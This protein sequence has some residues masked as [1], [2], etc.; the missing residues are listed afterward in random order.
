MTRPV[1][2]CRG[3]MA[4]CWVS[5]HTRSRAVACSKQPILAATPTMC[6]PTRF[7]GA[8]PRWSSRD[9]LLM[10]PRCCV[11]FASRLATIP[12]RT[13]R[14]RRRT[15][16]TRQGPAVMLPLPTHP[17]HKL[18]RV[19]AQ[20]PVHPRHSCARPPRPRPAATTSAVPRHPPRL[21]AA[22]RRCP[23]SSARQ[24]P[25]AR[26]HSLWRP[27]AAL[28]RRRSSSRVCRQ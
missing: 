7:P 28:A 11:V 17:P 2:A 18:V 8:A 20:V 19:A 3:V 4:H 9:T 6:V 1:V 23:R 25:L 5:N 27:R 15:T 12:T 16:R 10:V 14:R 13:L 21:V 26:R 24:Q 22:T